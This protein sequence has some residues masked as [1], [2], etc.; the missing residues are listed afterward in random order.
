MHDRMEIQEF[1]E[2][3]AIEVV[4]GVYLQQMA[5]GERMSLN[6]FQIDVGAETP[7]HRHEHEQFGYI[8]QGEVTF[9]VDGEEQVVSAGS[10]YLI[11]SEEPHAGVNRGSVPVRGI[12]IFS[13]PRR[14]PDWKD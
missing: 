7:M 12:D 13:P 2:R 14:D 8:Y 9:T 3:Q 10:S 11:P 1:D 6:H 5:V 4:D